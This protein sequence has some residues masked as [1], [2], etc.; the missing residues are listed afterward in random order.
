M[1]DNLLSECM[2]FGF[3]RGFEMRIDEHKMKM[4]GKMRISFTK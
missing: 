4:H 2:F 3:N 1:I